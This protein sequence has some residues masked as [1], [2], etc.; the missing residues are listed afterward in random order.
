MCIRDRRSAWYYD[1]VE[2]A[3]D[4]GLFSGDE[5]GFFNPQKDITR[6]EFVQVLYNALALSLIHI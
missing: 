2:S 4:M 1:Y 3:A 6:A 5:R